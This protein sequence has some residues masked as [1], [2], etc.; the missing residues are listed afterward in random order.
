MEKNIFSHIICFHAVNIYD[1][2]YLS[3]RAYEKIKKLGAV[4]SIAHVEKYEKIKEEENL[5]IRKSYII[6]PTD[7]FKHMWNIVMVIILISVGLF[8]PFRVCFVE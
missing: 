7:G 5:K 6:Y 3:F 1:L 2:S 8:T 4:R